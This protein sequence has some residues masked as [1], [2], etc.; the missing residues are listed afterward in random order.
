MLTRAQQVAKGI[1]PGKQAG[2]LEHNI[3]TELN[4]AMNQL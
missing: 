3:A 2:S 4:K 1:V